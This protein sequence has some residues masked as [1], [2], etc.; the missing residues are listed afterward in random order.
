MNCKYAKYSNFKNMPPY[1]TNTNQ[2]TFTEKHL[3]TWSW[4]TLA[5]RNTLHPHLIISK[6]SKSVL[7]SRSIFKFP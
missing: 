6:P 1:T 7:P 3:M 2:F 5:L 4:N